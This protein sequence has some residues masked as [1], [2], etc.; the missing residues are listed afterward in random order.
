[1]TRCKS[2]KQGELTERTVAEYEYNLLD[3][4]FKV[5]LANSVVERICSKCGRRSGVAIPEHQQLESL[6][7]V[8][9]ITDS[10]KLSGR[11]VRFLRKVLGL[12]SRELADELGLAPET[13]S[14]IENGRT[15]IGNSYERILRTRVWLEKVWDVTTIKVDR[16]ACVELGK[17]KIQSVYSADDNLA[18]RFHMAPVCHSDV[19]DHHEN[20]SNAVDEFVRKGWNSDQV[21]RKRS[22]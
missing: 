6:I 12:S 7:A 1:M 3:V 17:L 18:Y 20:C 21:E 11:E 13:L 10:R 15:P 9:R 8:S 16:N 5:V 14:K 2:C 4:P 19:V 22:A